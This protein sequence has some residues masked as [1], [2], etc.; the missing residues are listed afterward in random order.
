MDIDSSIKCQSLKVD[1]ICER[2][3]STEERFQ[4]IG[5]YG[6]DDKEPKCVWSHVVFTKT[7]PPWERG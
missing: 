4:E 1:E 3:G 5:L 6:G 2:K 7:H